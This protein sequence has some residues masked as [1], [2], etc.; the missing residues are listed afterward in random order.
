MYSR[1]RF[2]FA[3]DRRGARRPASNGVIQWYSVK[4]SRFQ[5]ARAASPCT[6]L[7]S[8][9]ITEAKKEIVERAGAQ[10]DVRIPLHDIRSTAVCEASHLFCR[11]IRGLDVLF[12]SI[13]CDLTRAPTPSRSHVPRC[14]SF[15][16]RRTRRGFIAPVFCGRLRVRLL[17]VVYSFVNI[18]IRWYSSSHV[19]SALRSTSKNATEGRV[20]VSVLIPRVFRGAT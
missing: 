2:R 18:G 13:N 10:A 8:R 20:C 3:G 15:G 9:W 16:N 6:A 1:T 11:C 4:A 12:R 17:D 5:R 7:A 19:R 14:L